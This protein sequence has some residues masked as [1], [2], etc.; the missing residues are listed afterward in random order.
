LFNTS[1]AGEGVSAPIAETER[2]NNNHPI[3]SF[4]N[5]PVP[6]GISRSE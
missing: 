1:K 3:V 6:E 2:I 5:R 4:M